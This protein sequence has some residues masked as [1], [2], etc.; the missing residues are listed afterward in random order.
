MSPTTPAICVQG[1]S[2]EYPNHRALEDVS[3]TIERSSVTALVGPNGAGK[4]TLMSCVAALSTPFS[5]S[6]EVDGIDVLENP[7]AGHRRIGYLKDFF[8]LYDALTVQQTL[9][10]AARNQ[11][12]T[13]GDCPAA[14]ARV[15]EQLDLESLLS[16][17]AGSL[18]RGQRQR[19]AIARA[20]VHQPAVLLLDEPA[21]GLDPEARN[22]LA[23]L[24]RRLRGEGMTLLVSSHILAE[25]AEYSTDMM[26]IRA[27]RLLEH[28]S[29]APQNVSSWLKLSLVAPPPAIPSCLLNHLQVTDVRLVGNDLVFSFAGDAKDRAALL[30]L[31]LDDTLEVCAF[32]S[33]D[34]GQQ[35]EYLRTVRATEG[36]SGVSE[37]SSTTEGLTV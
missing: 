36:P 30:R 10:H 28:R 15:I 8:G 4:T 5:G 31:C 17:T 16:Q 35:N 9:W 24:M 34:E 27:G 6:I 22:N 33:H 11:N 13:T 32:T 20:L 29:L 18:S 7:R 3:F 12:I 14:I 25:L 1:L 23:A 37:R 2:Y 19:L 21:S 26:I